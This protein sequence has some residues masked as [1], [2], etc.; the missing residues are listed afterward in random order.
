MHQVARGTPRWRSAWN[1]APESQATTPIVIRSAEATKVNWTPLFTAFLLFILTSVSYHLNLGW[2]AIAV[3]V[4]GILLQRDRIRFPVPLLL[5]AAFILWSYVC[6][7]HWEFRDFTFDHLI[8]LDKVWIIAFLA[9]NAL[10]TRGE[11][12]LFTLAYLSAFALFPARGAIQSTVVYHAARA[13]WAGLFGNPNDLAAAVLLQVSMLLGLLVAERSRFIRLNASL[14]LVVF[15]LLI[16]LTQS[17]GAILATGVFLVFLVLRSRRR[18]Q[19]LF[20]LAVVVALVVPLAPE[21]VWDRM[22]GLSRV[23]TSQDFADVDPEGSARNR[24]NIWRVAGM[25]IRDHPITGVG[26]GAYPFVH[27]IYAVANGVDEARGRRDTHSTYLNILAENGVPGLLLFLGI[28]GTTLWDAE[29]A[30]RR[31]REVLPRQ[32][33]QLGLLQCGILS[34][35]CAGLFGSFGYLSLLYIQLMLVWCTAR[36]CE[37]DMDAIGPSQGSM[38]GARDTIAP[39]ALRLSARTG[40]S[41]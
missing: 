23:T 20:R 14:G 37:R 33:E 21:S 6:I 26:S 5:F 19:F 36:A 40:G 3:G 8:D 24:Y 7:S 1:G 31:C 41:R 32:A 16:L 35:L 11:L 17:R 12:R 4:V 22:A 28:L 15:S 30:R 39:R 10:R 27:A 2:P 13:S 9:A 29:R 18:V 38:S 34:F 25:I